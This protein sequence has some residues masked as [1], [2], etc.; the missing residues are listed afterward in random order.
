VF[1]LFRKFFWLVLGFTLGVMSS[2]AVTRR[3]RRVVQRLAPADVVDR[4]SDNVKSAVS[5]GRNAMRSR[6]VELNQGFE[7]A[8]GQ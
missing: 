8:T 2:W 5:E 6:E 7:R 4:W 3:V 1:R